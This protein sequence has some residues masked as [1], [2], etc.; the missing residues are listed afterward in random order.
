MKKKKEKNDEKVKSSRPWPDPP[1]DP[2]PKPPPEG[3]GFSLETISV[4]VGSE[5]KEKDG[6]KLSLKELM[7]MQNEFDQKHSGTFDWGVTITEKNL[8]LLSFRI[9]CM[10]SELGEAANLVKKVLRGDFALEEIKGE[11]VEEITDLFIYLIITC[12]QLG[13]DLEEAYLN[14]LGKNILRFKRYEIPG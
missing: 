1:K 9:V 13:I 6:E 2:N 10:T 11:L 5:K 3:E 12:N 4:Q 7:E 14:K 8:E